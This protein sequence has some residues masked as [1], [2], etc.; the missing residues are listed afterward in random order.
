MQPARIF[1]GLRA[2]RLPLVGV[3]LAVFVRTFLAQG[4]AVS[5]VSMSP[6]LL[7]GDHVLV[8]RLT[9]ALPASRWL[10]A[11]PIRR[12]DVVAIRSP[13][14]P[15]TLLIKRCEAVP[16]D[17]VDFDGDSLK[18][19]EGEYWMV[20]DN[21]DRSLDSRSFGPVSRQAILGRAT[22]IYWSRK[23][24]F[25][26]GNPMEPIPQTDPLMH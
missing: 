3:V 20:G 9:A 4:L 13:E 5:S 19:S 14:D 17:T 21:L 7:P 12:G 24:R 8:E 16:G 1:T 2:L 25:E 10:P 23:A 18:L 11:R 26:N 15:R 6:T 22:L